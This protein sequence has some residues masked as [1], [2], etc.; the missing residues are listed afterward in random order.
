MYR[1]YFSQGHSLLSEK[2]QDLC[3][4]LLYE[5]LIGGGG[6]QMSPKQ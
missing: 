4:I 1:Y 3:K 6:V 5:F 2:S